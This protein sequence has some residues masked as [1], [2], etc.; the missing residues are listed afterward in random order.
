MWLLNCSTH[1]LELNDVDGLD[2]RQYW[3]L[4]HTWGPEEVSFQDMQNLQLAA[5]K[6]GF[7]KIK[8]MCDL[9]SRNGQKYV[10]IDTC[11]IDKTSSAELSESIN[12]M[13][14]W[15]QSADRCIAYLEDLE[16]D[17]G[18][19]TGDGE[20]IDDEIAE[21]F[22][23]CRW[24]TRG[25][26]LQEL[27]APGVVDF[28]DRA[29]NFRGTRNKLSGPIS[30]V[31]GIDMAV[32][33]EPRSLHALSIAKRMSW[34]ANRKTTRLEDKAYCL[35]GIFNVH[36]PLIYGEREQAFIRLQQTIAQKYNDMSL[37]AWVFSTS[38]NSSGILAR[39]PLHFAGCSS[40][41][42][43]RDPLLPSPSWI[44]SNAGI[45]MTTALDTSHKAKYRQYR[46]A[47]GRLSNY[48]SLYERPFKQSRPGVTLYP[49]LFLHCRVSQDPLDD[50]PRD[51][52]VLVI[53]L[54]K[55]DSGFFRHAPGELYSV[56][57]SSMRF[58]EPQAIRIQMSPWQSPPLPLDARLNPSRKHESNTLRV[59][60]GVH[61]S[62][63]PEVKFGYT[64]HPA[65]LW[66][67][68]DAYFPDA[69]SDL[70]EDITLAAVEITMSS[71]R[72]PQATHTC[73]LFCGVVGRVRIPWVE[74]ACEGPG[75]LVHVLGKRACKRSEL[76]NPYSLMSVVAELRGKFMGASLDP[77]SLRHRCV[78]SCPPIQL[79]L[80]ASKFS[81]STDPRGRRALTT[82][83][84]V[85][86]DASALPGPS[87]PPTETSSI[88]NGS[89]PETRIGKHDNPLLSFARG[90]FS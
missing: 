90:L 64:Y 54:R 70:L 36:M 8:S 24:F 61:A 6:R 77:A 42:P 80:S 30:R 17:P 38:S 79:E 2:S 35:L 19:E 23:G 7:Q 28:Y 78:I 10:W 66:D 48:E 15:Y 37:F 69:R 31:T 51:P 74:L 40:V 9:A 72:D 62:V 43:V 44:I 34:A 3:I 13:F 60:W 1:L 85:K 53:C 58:T 45:E 55:T 63:V 47:G 68:G 76:A 27:L 50:D 83:I 59:S 84:F 33:I 32:L 65:H 73:W 12:S 20:Q 18:H 86:L 46:R 52:Q 88:E 14:H 81:W 5:K 49:R 67:R 39:D 4:S 82:T 26:T 25:W 11:C 57:L 75:G 71:P 29:W 89:E 41:E 87:G 16:P 56:K 22:H 21:A